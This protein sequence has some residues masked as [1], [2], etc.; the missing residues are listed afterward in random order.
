MSSVEGTRCRAAY[1]G[2]G[3]GHDPGPRA[4]ARRVK[5]PARRTR[6]SAVGIDRRPEAIGRAGSDEPSS[7]THPRA[8]RAVFLC[9]SFRRT[10][11]QRPQP[12]RA[13]RGTSLVE[14]WRSDCGL[15]VRRG[16]PQARSNGL[17]HRL[18]MAIDDG[19][20][21]AGDRRAGAARV[22]R[23]REHERVL[24]RGMCAPGTAHGTARAPRILPTLPQRPPR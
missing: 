11:G 10:D 15:P 12:S 9:G 21:R 13:A 17:A 18:A 5:S 8:V 1:I 2:H 16:G 4:P 20:A 23:W 14:E 6:R 24:R 19:A 3:T 22:H 7:L